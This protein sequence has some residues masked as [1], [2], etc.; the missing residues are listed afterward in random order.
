MPDFRF[1]AQKCHLTYKTHIPFDL[2]KERMGNIAGGYN[3]LSMVHE[4]GDTEEANATPYEHTHVAVRFKKKPDLSSQ[5][6]FDIDV[7]IIDKDENG[8]DKL[9]ENGDTVWIPMPV[10]PHIQ[11][12]RSLDWFIHVIQKYHKGHK[13][14]A[15]GTKYTIDPVK[16]EQIGCEEFDEMAEKWAIV[17][18]WD[19][20]AEACL[21]I[22]IIP[23]TVTDVAT[24]IRCKKRKRPVRA[25]YTGPWKWPM[26][27]NIRSTMIC[28]PS[29]CGKTQFAKAHFKNALFVTH[30][31][32]LRE[33]DPDKHD[34]IIFDDMDFKDLSRNTQIQIAD[35]DDDRSINCRY[36]PAEIPAHTRKLFT[37][38]DPCFNM[39]DPAIRRRINII[40]VK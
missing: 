32:K 20:V 11:I 35:W 27:E 15:D 19:D 8:E 29:E 16:I 40:R 36:S 22:G 7:P 12:K 39:G 13:T 37:C 18:E 28:G 34:G 14:K 4:I 9:D 30:I 3:V 31:D 38:N 33:Y 21:E 17:K 6:C 2:I 26:V 24:A 23:K 5:F 10:H 1:T 25:P